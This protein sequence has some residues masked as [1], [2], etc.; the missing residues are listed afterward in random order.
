MGR[1]RL[2]GWDNLPDRIP[3]HLRQALFRNDTMCT[4][5]FSAR[6]MS[7]SERWTDRPVRSRRSPYAGQTATMCSM[8]SGR[9]R[10]Q[11]GQELSGANFSAAPHQNRD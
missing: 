2:Y 6:T 1:E 10:L 8:V 9:P 5:P 4:K 11:Q 3:S 7:A